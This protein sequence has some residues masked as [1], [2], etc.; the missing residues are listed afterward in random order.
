MK[1]NVFFVVL[2][3]CLT[4]SLGFK[5]ILGKMPKLGYFGPHI[6]SVLH[7]IWDQFRLCFNPCD[8]I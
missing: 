2:T 7:G 1:K 8:A 5:D 3:K 6:R 4:C